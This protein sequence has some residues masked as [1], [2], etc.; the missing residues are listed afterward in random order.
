M[1]LEPAK[2]W[3]DTG[4]IQPPTADVNATFAG[5]PKAWLL[6]GVVRA[7]VNAG[8]GAGEGAGVCCAET[9][10]AK[11]TIPARTASAQT[12]LKSD[13]VFISCYNTEEVKSLSIRFRQKN[14]VIEIVF[15][16]FLAS[17]RDWSCNTP[18]NKL[19]L[20]HLTKRRSLNSVSLRTT[21]SHL[22]GSGQSLRFAWETFSTSHANGRKDL[23]APCLKSF[24]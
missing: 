4:S 22:P 5:A 24:S 7:I 17:F 20:G 9:R 11:V 18:E 14:G 13:F 21:A 16:F 23:D 10:V 12:C 3:T 15:G 2:Y 6:V 19:K 8:T 1:L